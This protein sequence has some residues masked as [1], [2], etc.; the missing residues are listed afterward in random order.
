MDEL[1]FCVGKR[2]I[3]NCTYINLSRYFEFESDRFLLRSMRRRYGIPDHDQRPFNVAYSAARL[4]QD[5][6]RKLPRNGPTF[7]QSTPLGHGPTGP[8]IVSNILVNV[9]SSNGSIEEGYGLAAYPSPVPVTLQV[10]GLDKSAKH[11]CVSSFQ[12][13]TVT[14][15]FLVHNGHHFPSA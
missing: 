4:A 7:D 8:G 9:C 3:T 2:D 12:N 14:H 1:F 11:M 15:L 5:D 13:P 6:T 10:T